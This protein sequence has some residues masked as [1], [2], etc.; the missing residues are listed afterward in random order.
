MEA[1][2]PTTSVRPLLSWPT[3][4]LLFMLQ[5][6]TGTQQTAIAIQHPPSAS[7]VEDKRK[8]SKSKRQHA[9]RVVSQRI[10]QFVRPLLSRPT[11][12][13]LFMLIQSTGTQHTTIVIQHPP[14]ASPVEDTYPVQ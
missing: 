12:P 8:K 6:S 11:L 14:S 5:Q 4:P 9:P 1:S 3:L 2:P 7:P 13:L 10:Y